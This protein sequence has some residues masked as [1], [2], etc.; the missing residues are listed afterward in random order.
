MSEVTVT[1]AI[2]PI[3][4]KVACLDVMDNT[5]SFVTFYVE[6]LI[7]FS[8]D[9]VIDGH[10]FP[11]SKEQVIFLRDFLTDHVIKGME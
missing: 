3:D 1:K 9:D 10:K 4:G 8:N 5:C 2:R 6:G 11:M 7:Y